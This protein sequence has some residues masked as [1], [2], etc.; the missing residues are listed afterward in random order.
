MTQQELSSFLH[1]CDCPANEGISSLKNE[2]KFPRIDYWEILWEDVM[3]SG[4]EYCG[5][6]TWQVSFYA[7]RPR[8]PKLIK[9]KKKLNE[10]GYHPEI[11]HEYIQEDRVWHS[12]FSLTTDGEI[13]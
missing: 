1:S 12:Y 3:A 7:K 8:D 6:T 11:A 5:K 4:D 2:K 9:L 13:E 10:S